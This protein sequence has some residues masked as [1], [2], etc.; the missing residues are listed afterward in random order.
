MGW[1]GRGIGDFGS[2]VGQGYDINL[3]WKERLQNMAL[4]QARQRLEELKQPLELQEL[5]QRIRQAAAPQYMGTVKTPGGGESA[6]IREPQAGTIT[7]KDILP[8]L[9]PEQADARIGAM[10][11]TAPTHQAKLL[12]SSIRERL[13]DPNADPAAILADAEKA[14]EKY[15]EAGKPQ[16]KE[17]VDLTKGVITHY[18]EEGNATTY[19]IFKGNK[20]NPDLL[21]AQRE[22]VESAIQSNT[23]KFNQQL[24]LQKQRMEAYAATYAKMR[25]LVNQYSVIDRTTGEPVMVNA[26]IINANP[27]RYMAASI[28]QQLKNR[29]GIFDEIGVTAKQFDSALA[30]MSDQDFKTLPRAELA[31][32]L[33]SP[34]P[35][36]AWDLFVQSEVAGSLTPAQQEYAIMLESLAESAMALRTIGGQGQGSDMLR[37]AIV[38]M[39]PGPA[40]PTKSYA[41]RQ[42]EVFNTQVAALHRAIPSSESLGMGAGTTPTGGAEGSL[43][44]QIMKAIGKK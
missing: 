12:L 15:L 31:M 9:K 13:N 25:G 32:V 14:N 16:K 18:D 37:G 29:A 4:A 22:F 20:I 39:L 23:N 26:N 30:G 2:Q 34:D 6:I 27:G 28:G 41:R 5:Q 35:K 19:P 42:M 36:S 8:G 3:G 1:L 40:T 24:E 43:D 38:S 10:I 17:D 44:D 7:T 33:R 11:Q 21:D